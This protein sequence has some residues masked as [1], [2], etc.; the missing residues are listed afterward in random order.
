MHVQ[1]VSREQSPVTPNTNDTEESLEIVIL[2]PR[3]FL[4]ESD[5][6]NQEVNSLMK[7]GSELEEK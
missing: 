5:R 3:I 2:Q 6:S 4:F 1:H 7:K